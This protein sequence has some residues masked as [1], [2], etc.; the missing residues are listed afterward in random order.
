MLRVAVIGV[1]LV[2]FLC[3]LEIFVNEMHVTHDSN[4]SSFIGKD[5]FINILFVFN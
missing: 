2:L 3:D 1:G 4:V 5:K